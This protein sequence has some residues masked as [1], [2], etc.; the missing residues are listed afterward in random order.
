[1][2]DGLIALMLV[3]MLYG[4]LVCLAIWAV[5]DNWLDKRSYRKRQETAR[6]WYMNLPEARQARE[7]SK[8]VESELSTVFWVVP[9]ES[10]L[11]AVA[12]SWNARTGTITFDD[13]PPDGTA[14]VYDY[15]GQ[16]DE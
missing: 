10:E 8:R 3:G 1:M 14:I 15:G 11:K 9:G 16:S 2:S 7:L 6:E 12:Y 13:P 4:A 5:V